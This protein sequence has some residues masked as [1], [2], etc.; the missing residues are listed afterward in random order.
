MATPVLCHAHV[1]FHS[2]K[3]NNCYTSTQTQASRTQKNV[4]TSY[5]NVRS[6]QKCIVWS[7]FD[8][9]KFVYERAY[10][11]SRSVIGGRWARDMVWFLLYVKTVVVRVFFSFSFHFLRFPLCF[12]WRMYSCKAN[13]VEEKI[14]QETI[15]KT[16][17]FDAVTSLL[18]FSFHFCIIIVA[19]YCCCCLLAIEY[20]WILFYSSHR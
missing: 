9:C 8:Q 12:A 20:N 7:L 4:R 19:A 1:R 2:A 6:H 14:D 16:L 3:Y 10:I 15:D 11:V 18:L 5:R 17:L 13:G